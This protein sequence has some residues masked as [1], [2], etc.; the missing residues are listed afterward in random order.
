MGEAGERR[1]RVKDSWAVVSILL[2]ALLVRL[3]V[4]FFA[5]D[6]PICC[7]A[8]DYLRHGASIADGD[9]Y[10]QSLL[11]ADGGPTVLRPPAYPSF[12]GAVLVVPGTGHRAIRV[13]QAALGTITVGLLML[14]A[15]QMLRSRRAVLVTGALA[16]IYPVL[17]FQ[18]TAFLSEILFIPLEVAALCAAWKLRDADR[19]AT[20]WVIATGVAVG[21]ATLTRQTGMLLA[22]PV[23]AIVCSV[24]RSW[25]TRISRIAAVGAI[26]L[27]VVA[28]W[29][30]RNYL[31][32]D[33]LVLV[34]RQTGLQLAGIYNDESR[35]DPDHPARWYPPVDVKRDAPLF[36]QPGLDELELDDELT[37]RAVDYARAHP[38]YVVEAVLRNSVRMLDLE[39]SM[40]DIDALQL[41]VTPHQAMLMRATWVLLAVLA[42]I[43]WFTD[44]RRR[45]PWYV[46]ASP[47]VFFAAGAVTAGLV[48]YR[49]PI[50]PFVVLLAAAALTSLYDRIRP[51]PSST[52]AG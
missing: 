9:V 11:V 20:R 15:H 16:A 50:D 44:L 49:V 26:A 21:L 38:G 13:A 18:S 30:A 29:T 22:V 2:A 51:A 34:G 7:D 31:A 39:P 27:V 25:G 42:G 33:H 47:L 52:G 10:P 23:I 46:W 8:D 17:V 32:T 4:V 28:P 37:N 41:N 6:A 12:L 24:P 40:N 5:A 48:R 19:H 35:L 36:T 1:P 45:V 43:G 3:A 14:L